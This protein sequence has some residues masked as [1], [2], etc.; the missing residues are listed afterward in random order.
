MYKHEPGA[1][2]IGQVM[3]LVGKR[4]AVQGRVDGQEKEQNVGNVAK[5]IPRHRQNPCSHKNERGPEGSG[6][7]L[8]ARL[9]GFHCVAR[10]RLDV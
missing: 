3:Q 2:G 1:N 4:D 8:P 7:S 10:Q 6:E 9:A 5:P